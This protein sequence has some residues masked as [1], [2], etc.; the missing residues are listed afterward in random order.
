MQD[1]ER[2]KSFSCLQWQRIFFHV[3]GAALV[4]RSDVTTQSSR[5]P[6]LSWVCGSSWCASVVLLQIL[7]F[8]W[9]YSTGNS[10]KK[11]VECQQN[12]LPTH[13][14]HDSC[15][16]CSKSDVPGWLIGIS[17]RSPA[18]CAGVLHK[19]RATLLFWRIRRRVPADIP[20]LKLVLFMYS[21]P[22]NILRLVKKRSWGFIQRLN[23]TWYKGGIGL[24]DLKA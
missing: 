9:Y 12:L 19:S 13:T 6:Q 3:F 21:L 15:I 5:P 7:Q 2:L 8:Y 22:Q 17:W 16:W 4:I 23:W 18:S 1:L 10:M 11:D 14:G 24:Y 20:L